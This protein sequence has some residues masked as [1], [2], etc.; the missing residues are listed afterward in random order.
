MPGFALVPFLDRMVRIA[1][2]VPW[3]QGF[4][5][6]ANAGALGLIAAVIIQLAGS[7][8]VDPLTALLGMGAF[9]IVLRWPLAAPAVVIAAGVAGLFR[10]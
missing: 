8:I 7:S 6:G 2:R 4:V 1:E 9:A 5:D 10:L 3:V